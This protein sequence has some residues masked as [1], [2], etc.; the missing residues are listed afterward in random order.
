MCTNKRTVGEGYGCCG[1][2]FR[3]ALRL[4]L[5]QHDCMLYKMTLCKDNLQ[6]GLLSKGSVHGG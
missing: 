3:P 4:A 1:E 2:M 5:V 6:R